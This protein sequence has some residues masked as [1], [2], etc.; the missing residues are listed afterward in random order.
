VETQLEHDSQPPRRHLL[1]SVVSLARPFWVE[2]VQK[3]ACPAQAKQEK[4][5][6]LV[7]Q[8][9]GLEK[10]KPAVENEVV[11]QRL[12]EPQCCGGGGP[13]SGHQRNTDDDI[14]HSI[15]GNRVDRR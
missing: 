7:Q 1:Q 6:T 9:W 11:R 15:A 3:Q 13:Q 12:P 2:S 14:E 8:R 10:V 5:R 4:Q